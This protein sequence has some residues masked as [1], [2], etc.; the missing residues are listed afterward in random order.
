MIRALQQLLCFAENPRFFRG[1]FQLI[2]I[3]WNEQY[4]LYAIKKKI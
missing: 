1:L 4:I 3:Y 2:A